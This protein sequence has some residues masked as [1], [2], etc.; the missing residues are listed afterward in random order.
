MKTKY[1][2]GIQNK[3]KTF[4][5]ILSPSFLVSSVSLPF[6]LNIVRKK[7]ICSI[8][9]IAF[10]STDPDSSTRVDHHNSRRIML[11]F[12]KMI[13]NSE[14]LGII[15]LVDECYA[16]KIDF[17]QERQQMEDDDWKERV[18]RDYDKYSQMT[19]GYQQSREGNKPYKK[20]WELTA[21]ANENTFNSRCYIEEYR[22][23]GFGLNDLK[24]YWNYEQINYISSPSTMEEEIQ[25]QDK[26]AKRYI[27]QFPINKRQNQGK[28]CIVGKLHAGVQ[29]LVHQVK[30][31]K[32]VI[33]LDYGDERMPGGGYLEGWT[34]QEE[35]ILFNSDCY[36]ALMDI[37][38][39]KLDSSYIIPEF[40][41]F[42]V[43]NVTF[44]LP[45]SFYPYQARKADVVVA[46]CYDLTNE[47]GI[48]RKP[49]HQK[50]VDE[51]TRE[52]LTSVIAAAQLN[53]E[54][55]GSNT[56]LLL[57]P[58][59]SGAFKND[60]H[61]IARLWKDILDRPIP[62]YNVNGDDDDSST[63][64]S[65]YLFDEIWFNCYD[66]DNTRVFEE[67]FETQRS[68][69]QTEDQQIRGADFYSLYNI[70]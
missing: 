24:I 66:E 12:L 3:C 4:F 65:R 53:T 33:V 22:S 19:E 36:R 20:Y 18:D 9:N 67:I 7:D 44:V 56:V 69:H 31:G 34:T 2:H 37:K 64:A 28:I 30:V 41:V 5:V 15:E 60:V 35:T 42:Y 26:E 59:G 40:G 47:H 10:A 46:A 6:P 17:E 11:K 58:I 55:D 27:E 8:V 25:D 68:A 62:S 63:V 16:R 51:N 13:K 32:Q 70:L 61:I 43:K 23:R 38:Y 29:Q 1:C 14:D 54:G 48:Y 21:E 45:G 57:G 39:K 49:D 52:K 50:D